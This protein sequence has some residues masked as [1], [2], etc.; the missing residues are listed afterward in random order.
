MPTRE[1]S[2][3]DRALIAEEEQIFQDLMNAIRQA[4][5]QRRASYDEM[6][7]RLEALRDEASKAKSADLP[8]LFDQMNTQRAI[9]EHK[10]EGR[11]PDVQSPYFAH[12]CL[13]EKGKR[14]DVL[15]G[16]CTFLDSRKLPLID[17]KHAPISRIFFSYREGEEYEEELPGRL[18]TGTVIKRR[19]LT[20]FNG[21]LL[22]IHAGDRH[23]RSTPEGWVR[24]SG[25]FL[26]QLA[27]GAGSAKRSL[28][29]GLNLTQTPAPEVSAL[30]DP[31]QFRLLTA[32]SEDPLLI[33]GGAGCGKTT[34]ALHRMAFLQFRHAQ[35]FPQNKML[36]I[37]PEEG[38]VRLSRKLLDSLGL[39]D[40]DVKTF[41]SWVEVQARRIIRALPDKLSSYVPANV[42]RIK[43][44][45][46]LLEAF[47]EIVRR[48]IEEIITSAETQLPGSSEVYTLLRERTDIPMLERLA[49]AEDRL[50][51]STEQSGG[52][53]VGLRVTSIKKFFEARRKRYGN[54]LG[55]RLDLFTNWDILTFIAERSGG[56]I[57][58][59]MLRDLVSHVLDQLGPSAEESFGHY[60][61]ERLETVD[62]RSL[63]ET[64]S[65]QSLAGTMDVEDFAVLLE[66]YFYKSGRETS[67]HGRL[68]KYSHMVIDEAQDMASVELRVLSRALEDEAAITIAGDAAQQ[69]DPTHSFESWERVLEQLGLPQVHAQQL[70]TTYRSTRDI[71]AFAHGILGPIAPAEPPKA[72]REGLPVART[73]FPDEGQMVV[74]L[75][76]TLTNLIISEPLA[77]V[78]IITKT[79]DYALALYKLLQ[80]VPKIRLVENGAFDFKPGIEVTPASEVKGLEFDYVVIPDANMNVYFDK[81]EDRRLLHVAATRAIHQLWVISVGRE[82]MILPTEADL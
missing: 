71:A 9:F 11:L 56:T 64:E 46:A 26:P 67:S 27:G 33:L 74:F 31:Q 35:R 57:T 8:A 70:K 5:Q 18:A 21:K 68:K 55:D 78:A 32:D 23:Y 30:L 43:R 81:P 38:L 47:P 12:M 19:V 42:S 14:R 40:V 6:G 48:Q 36:V 2:P 37:V 22:R 54:T 16:H 13:E 44:H 60:D 34:I 61:A 25:S 73:L 41:D 80:D 52:A 75:S 45:P 3:E 65:E 77:S 62:G 39:K 50:I 1:L 4:R 72:L 82:S 10:S 69:I 7:R 58:E 63:I 59:G 51:R 15:L 76:E 24:E 79:E 17:W 66:L 49:Q 28:Q 29:G 53:A 20:I